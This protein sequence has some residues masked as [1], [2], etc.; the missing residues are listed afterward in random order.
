MNENPLSVIFLHQT[1]VKWVKFAEF[2]RSRQFYFILGKYG[3]F[4]LE[5]IL[6]TKLAVDL[7][8]LSALLHENINKQSTHF[9]VRKWDILTFYD[10]EVIIIFYDIT[11]AQSFFSVCLLAFRAKSKIPFF[12]SFA[13]FKSE[14]NFAAKALFLLIKLEF[15][16]LECLL[17]CERFLSC[18]KPFNPP[19]LWEKE[20]KGEGKRMLY[21]FN[22]LNLKRRRFPSWRNNNW[23]QVGSSTKL[24]RVLE[25]LHTSYSLT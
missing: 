6:C 24:Y 17:S 10:Y 21:Y 8:G 1:K 3:R 15:I 13:N 18:H 25:S 20:G 4:L 19:F 9:F 2:P 12:L 23:R 11:R 14:N 16:L 5:I 7:G 22:F